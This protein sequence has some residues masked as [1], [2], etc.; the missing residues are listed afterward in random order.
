M[1]IINYS[2]AFKALDIHIKTH[3]SNSER[4][5]DKIRQSTTYTAKN[6]IKIY[7]LSLLKASNIQAIDSKNPPSLR[8]NN[9]Q[10]AKMGNA[11]PR[12]IQRHIIK[13]MECKI[14]IEKIWH[15]SNS[16]YELQV[17]PEILLIRSEKPI[18]KFKIDKNKYSYQPSRKQDIKNNKTT[19]CP[20][21]D[22][23]NN[24]YIN[25]KI[26]AV[27]NLKSQ[28]SSLPLTNSNESRNATRNT[29]TGY[30]G[31]IDPKK[32][33]DAGEIERIK[34]VTNQTG[35]EISAVDKA[36][37]ASLSLYVNSLWKLARNTLYKEYH[38][39]QSQ[40]NQAQKL[41]YLWY[42]PVPEKDMAR[43]HQVYVDRIEIV[44]KYLIKDP[45]NRYVQ[46]PNKYFDPK[47]KY[48]FTGTRSW[49]FKEKEKQK[50]LQCKL[51]LNAQV[52][53]F[54][55][56]ERKE[57]SKQKPRLELFRRCETR[58]GKLGKPE[59]TDAF[60]ASVLEHFTYQFLY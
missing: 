58:I 51:I 46:L 32:N 53:T 30:T 25:N 31:K 16:S 52:R 8:T 49:Y 15:G 26:I 60:H 59:L 50:E 7:G 12:T 43:V 2:R 10:L 3:N 44:Q 41:L 13:L 54:L 28:M 6:I 22:T 37:S 21:T 27:D 1:S 38:L 19:N 55:N 34:R 39:T 14:I 24:S 33:N 17:N 29:L 56:N 36:R 35:A 20:H 5:S 9:A 23:S 11:S 57:T 18:D 45:K 48:G 42:D 47:N 40:I 4:L